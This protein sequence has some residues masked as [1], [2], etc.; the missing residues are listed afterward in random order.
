VRQTALY[1]ASV[2]WV[3][4]AGYAPLARNDF[5]PRNGDGEAAQRHQQVDLDL[6][7]FE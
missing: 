1:A 3:G 2:E 7:T 6:E 4:K 5:N